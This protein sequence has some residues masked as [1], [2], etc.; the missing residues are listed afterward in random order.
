[1]NA[2][3][4]MLMGRVTVFFSL[5]LVWS[6]T[7]MDAQREC[8][9]QDGCDSIILGVKLENEIEVGKKDRKGYAACNK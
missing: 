6:L 7:E 4:C 5:C 8:I 9:F 3:S 2:F 1:M